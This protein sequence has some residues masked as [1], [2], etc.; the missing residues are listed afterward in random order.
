MWFSQ[1]YSDT[2]VVLWEWINSKLLLLSIDFPNIYPLFDKVDIAS[3]QSVFLDSR[4]ILKELRGD[5]STTD[6]SG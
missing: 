3:T 2:L 5:R 1:N 4:A 6:D